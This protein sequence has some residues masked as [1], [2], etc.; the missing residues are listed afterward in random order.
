MKDNIEGQ[1][2][3]NDYYRTPVTEQKR[4][5]LIQRDT[6]EVHVI[7][8][9]RVDSAPVSWAEA[10]AA[11]LSAA[12]D[13]ENTRR[14]YARHLRCARDF[15]Q[16]RS[17]EDVTGVQLA[18]YRAKVLAMDLSP[19]SKNQDLAAT[20]AFLTYLADMGAP[21]LPARTVRT[22]LKSPS[23]TV[24]TRY[25]VISEAEMA[26]MLAA[27]RDD[28]ERAILAVF[29]GSG[30]RVSEVAA[31][32]VADLHEDF[33][34][35]SALFIH[36][37][38]GRRD[39]VVPIQPDVERLI[40]QYLKSTG[41]YL[42]GP[43]QLFL[44]DDRGASSRRAKSL[45]SRSLSRQVKEVAALAGISAKKVSPH[46]LRHS[47]ALRCLRSGASIL[48]VSKMLG[49]SSVVTTQRYLD[50]LGLGELR[51]NVPL[52]PIFQTESVDVADP[53]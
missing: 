25:Q 15:L 46:A 28:R 32:R 30:A 18:S 23:A 48:A 34:G 21:V 14:A 9:D 1:G 38:K 20:R 39:R 31:L 10:S 33:E 26:A 52:L 3:D 24:I 47:F 35:G 50:H 2:S 11:F 7:V 12:I 42:S 51:A 40:R 17:V 4:T 43:G 19:S 44:A 13:S 53:V 49:H 22:A 45:S 37:G 41:R 16:V 8:D 36:Q 27:A 6:Q 29:L 5:S